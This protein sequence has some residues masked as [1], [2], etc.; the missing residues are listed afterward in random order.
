MLTQLEVNKSSTNTG[1]KIFAFK[2]ELD[3]TNVDTTFPNIIIEIGD[4][5]HSRTLFD[6]SELT[7]LNS[8]SIGYIADIAQRTDD[9]GGKFSLCNLSN[10]VHDTLDLVGITSIVPIY[11]TADTAITEMSK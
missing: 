1:V 11:E 8:K 4:F 10:E 7:Y 9:G 3:E 5:S 6:L 2:G